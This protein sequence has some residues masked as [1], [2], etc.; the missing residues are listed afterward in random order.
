MKASYTTDGTTW[1]EVAASPGGPMQPVTVRFEPAE[2]V[3][4]IRFET[5]EFHAPE[6]WS[7]HEI[8]VFSTAG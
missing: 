3:R 1:H 7:I 2:M 4:T 8:Y 5:T 6:W